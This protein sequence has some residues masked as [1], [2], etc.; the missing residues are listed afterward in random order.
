MNKKGK[1]LEDTIRLIQESLIST[2]NT[3]VFQNYLIKN[4]SGQKREIDIL[5]SSNINS[6]ELKIAIECK[7]FNKKVPVKEIEAFQSKCERIKDIH[8]KVFVSS[9]GYQKDAIQAANF[10]GIELQ[11]ADRLDKESI[12]NWFNI[13]QIKLEILP[14]FDAPELIIDSTEEEI[15]TL[16]FSGR[17]YNSKTSKNIEIQKLLIENVEKNKNSIR[18]S[19]ILEWMKIDTSKKL[20]EFPVKFQLSFTKNYFIE[21]DCNKRIGLFGLNSS[22]YVKFKE[23]DANIIDA[24]E[25]IKTEYNENIARSVTIDLD[26]NSKSIIILGKDNKFSFFS[27]DDKGNTVKL[28]KLFEYNPKENKFKI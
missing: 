14:K 15:E 9:L 3:K 20:A 28:E 18:N 1:I 13:K 12:R 7:N 4:E 17:I 6:F 22:V 8:K 26:K 25:L 21:T 24:R 23:Q 10:F 16:V 19:S 27:T 2:P 5:I 11:T